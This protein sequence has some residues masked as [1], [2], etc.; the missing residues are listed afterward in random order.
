MLQYSGAVARITKISPDGYYY[1]L[2]IDAETWKWNDGML[3]DA[4]EDNWHPAS[5]EEFNAFLGDFLCV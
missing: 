2:D 4:K 5:D 1:K 3:V